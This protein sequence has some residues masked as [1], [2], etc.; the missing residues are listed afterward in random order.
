[1]I[2]I[3]LTRLLLPFLAFFARPRQMP[4]QRILVIQAAK[5][6]DAICTSPLLRELRLGFPQ[7]HITLYAGPAAAPL[8]QASPRIDAL[9]VV[10]LRQYKGLVA[11]WRLAWEIRR[12]GFDTVLCCN[13][14]ALWPSVLAWAGIPLR[15]GVV[16]NFRGRSMEA[17]RKLWTHGI[18]HQ[19]QRLIV[20]TYFEMLAVLGLAPIDRDKEVFS[21]PGAVARVAALLPAGGPTVGL[22][23]SAANKLKE[24]G[25]EKLA[26]VARLV[27]DARPEVRVVF[28]GGPGDGPQAEHLRSLLPSGLAP[29]L[30]DACGRLDLGDLPALVSRLDLFIGVDSGLT[31]LADALGVPLVSIAGPCNM[32][33]TRPVGARAVI[34]QEQLPCLPCAH[35]FRAPYSCRVGTRACIHQ[36]DAAR[37]ATAAIALLP[38]CPTEL[39]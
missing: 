7:A 10:D 35:I 29:R 3:L 5:I 28:L 1:M 26:A 9:Q 11:K 4:P 27:L 20:E 25:E 8:L 18:A 34:L 13:G 14:G 2:Q 6:G 37:I 16:P 32:A 21:A 33:E 17:A 23:V 39:H 12:Q 38:P 31:Y 36:I 30:L 15:I 22:A 24:L 19:G